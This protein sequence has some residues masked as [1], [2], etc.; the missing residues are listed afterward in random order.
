M[1][2]SLKNAIITAKRIQFVAPIS[3]ATSFSFAQQTNSSIDNIEL[4]F[5]TSLL[6]KPGLPLKKASKSKQ[7]YK[8]MSNPYENMG[9]VKSLHKSL[10]IANFTTMDVMHT[11]MNKAME[12]LVE[13]KYDEFFKFIFEIAAKDADASTSFYNL[14]CSEGLSSSFDSTSQAT[15][16]KFYDQ[17]I[18]LQPTLPLAYR[19]KGMLLLAQNQKIPALNCFNKALEMNKQDI[20]TLYQKAYLLHSI[21]SLKEA[22]SCYEEIT[23]LQP[24]SAE[25]YLCK[26]VIYIDLNLDIEA[27]TAFNR[28]ITL[29][30]K[31]HEAYFFKGE[32]YLEQKKFREAIM[33]YNQC[34]DIDPE[35]AEAYHEKAIALYLSGKTKDAIKIL[36]EAIEHS[37]DTPKYLKNLAKMQLETGSLDKALETCEKAIESDPEFAEAYY[38]KGN[39]LYYQGL[40]AGSLSCYSKASELEPSN[41][42]YLDRKSSLEKETMF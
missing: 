10:R 23:V 22:L 1:L 9:L 25:M 17:A 4:L 24:K 32:I 26:G 30:P 6:N 14:L 40:K 33:S 13:K 37:P 38:V 5:K 35:Y 41:E 39:V 19:Y 31:S 16:L 2:L 8:K 15:A 36:E 27:I 21:G 3:A 18:A 7:S 34:I 11:P 42:E 28:A 20:E 29:D 12:F